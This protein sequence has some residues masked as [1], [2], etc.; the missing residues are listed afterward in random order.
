MVD[1]KRSYFYGHS[2]DEATEAL[3]RFLNNG[4]PTYDHLL[5]ENQRL[6]QKVGRLE[7][8]VQRLRS[9]RQSGTSNQP[10]QRPG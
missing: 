1:R 3:D 5:A 10:S 6:R 4:L 7:A 8:E 2:R 9:H